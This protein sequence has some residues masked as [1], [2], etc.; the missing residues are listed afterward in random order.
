M[1]IL[2]RYIF[3]QLVGPFLAGAAGS[4]VIVT[5]GNLLR[6]VSLIAEGRA[7]R[8]VVLRWFVFRIPEDM[9]YVFPVG[10][11]LSTLLVFGRLSK[12]GEVTAMR[13]AGIS[14]AR[15]TLPVAAFGLVMTVLLF[16]F[17]DRVVPPS[18]HESQ[19]LWIK[20]IRLHQP[21]TTFKEHVLLRPS[22]HQLVYVRRYNTRTHEM[23][24]VMMRDYSEPGARLAR[25]VTAGRAI[26]RG[27]NTWELLSPKVFRPADPD[28]PGAG[29][30]ILRLDGL[31]VSIGDGPR[32]FI[33]EDRTPQE[34]ST[35]ELFGLIRRLEDRGL[36]NTTPLKVELYL[37][38]SFPFCVLIFAV[39]GTTMGLAN[40]RSGG[41]IGF[42][43]SLLVT[44]LYYV[45]MS[46]V[47]SLGKTGLIQPLL[48]AWVQ[49]IVFAGVGAWLV[50]GLNAR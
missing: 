34:M 48:S 11:L 30:R 33:E 8:W 20:R 37:K 5:F 35:R 47:S 9:Q 23:E 41:F 2:D 19:Q 12:N 15:L 16:A 44:F 43:L 24:S 39:I 31:Q 4:L 3:R 27:G 42:G 22:P 18:M 32:E 46:L 6:A 7:D 26:H 25:G 38:T 40:P 1:T 10:I 29:P 50:A 13:A 14:L 45:L 49:N 28:A 36:A 17:L 21:D